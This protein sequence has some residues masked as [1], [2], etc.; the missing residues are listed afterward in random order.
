MSD[1]PPLLLT[2]P[3]QPERGYPLSRTWSRP[4]PD[5]PGHLVFPAQSQVKA[6]EVQILFILGSGGGREWAGPFWLG[7]DWLLPEGLAWVSE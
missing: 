6:A 7:G 4:W 3:A 5:S 1:S 2:C